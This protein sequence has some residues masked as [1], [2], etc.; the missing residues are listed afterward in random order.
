MGSGFVEIGRRK[1]WLQCISIK[2]LMFGFHYLLIL[3]SFENLKGEH[4][5]PKPEKAPYAR[6]LLFGTTIAIAL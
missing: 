6:L 3:R 5:M 4:V 2:T 1:I